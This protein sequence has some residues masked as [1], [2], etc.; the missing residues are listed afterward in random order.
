ML[1]PL[2]HDRSIVGSKWVYKIKKNP[3]GNV[4]RYKARLM[5]QGFSQKHGINYLDT[6]SLV[7]RHTTM[8]ILLAVAAV[9]H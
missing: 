3:N 8:R 4:S 7:V 1:V 6:F 5:A 2:P 9:N